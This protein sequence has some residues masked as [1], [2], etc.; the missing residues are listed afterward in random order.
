VSRLDRLIEQA[1]V[2]GWG[3]ST[4][5]Q[6]VRLRQFLKAERSKIIAE[7]SNVVASALEQEILSCF[8]S[9]RQQAAQFEPHDRLVLEAAQMVRTRK[10]RDY[11]LTAHGSER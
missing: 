10:Y 2:D 6:F 4:L 5:Q 11:L 3:T 8:L 9:D 7:S 1:K